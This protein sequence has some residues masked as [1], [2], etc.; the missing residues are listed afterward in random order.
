MFFFVCFS[1]I[2]H[3]LP[4]HWWLQLAA[5]M[6]KS[7]V[8]NRAKRG[9]AGP[10]GPAGFVLAP[11]KH[12]C[13]LQRVPASLSSSQQ[14][15]P[16]SSGGQGEQE[17]EE[18]GKVEEKKEKE[19]RGRNNRKWRR[20]LKRNRR[21]RSW[22]SQRWCR[23][24]D[25]RGGGSGGGRGGGY[26]KTG[27]TESWRPFSLLLFSSACHLL[28]LHTH[29][30]PS[31]NRCEGGAERRC[32]G[33]ASTGGREEPYE[34]LENETLAARFTASGS[35]EPRRAKPTSVFLLRKRDTVVLVSLTVSLSLRPWSLYPL[36]CPVLIVNSALSAAENWMLPKISGINL[37][38]WMWVPFTPCSPFIEEIF[39]Y[40]LL[41]KLLLLL[42][43]PPPLSANQL[44]PPP[45]PLSSSS[46]EAARFSQTGWKCC[47]WEFSKGGWMNGRG[48]SSQLNL[49]G[50]FF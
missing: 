15:Q 17:E 34:A 38:F 41:I 4:K 12:N 14:L 28:K 3:K 6:L 31:K 13:Q 7:W 2:F 39:P 36:H 49:K 24:E 46:Q 18:T 19:R 29:C 25:H 22:W 43:L 45:L 26:E 27:D 16:R 30:Q 47:W 1:F 37:C 44:Q 50:F 9:A 10:A 35:P 48:G 11:N 21:W 40:L 32:D 23:E 20:R 42:Q 8:E 5:E 33:R